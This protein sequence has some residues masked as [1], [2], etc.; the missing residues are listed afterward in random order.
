MHKKG[1]LILGASS[2]FSFVVG[3]AVGYMA[4]KKECRA[5]ATKFVAKFIIDHDVNDVDLEEDFDDSSPEEETTPSPVIHARAIGY[6]NP[7]EAMRRLHPDLVAKARAISE[8]E[9]YSPRP[10]ESQRMTNIFEELRER[11]RLTATLEPI[12]QDPNLPHIIGREDFM[13]A[14]VG[15]H[16]TTLTYFTV[17]DVLVDEEDAPIT[18]VEKL[19]GVDNL[20]RFGHMS[21][22]PKVVYIRN[23]YVGADFEVIKSESSYSRD[24]LGFDS[25]GS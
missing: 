23:P 4:A 3:S 14:E 9:G 19:V 20:T 17:D 5:Y 1:W 6:A 21:D 8:R 15:Y 12:Q 25:T 18:E 24:V 7:Q 10:Q 11:R 16:Q 13:H 22:D 2:A